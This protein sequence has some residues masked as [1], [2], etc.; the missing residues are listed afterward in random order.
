MCEHRFAVLFGR[1]GQRQVLAAAGRADTPAARGDRRPGQPGG[2]AGA[3]PG[4]RGPPPRTGI[5]WPRRRAS[6]RAGSWSTS[7]R[8]S[9]P[10]AATRQERARFIDLLLAARD[11]GSRLRVLIAVRADFYARCAEH[12]GLADALSGAGLLVGPMTADELREAVVRPAQAGRAAG[13]A[14]ADRADRG[15]GPRPSPADCRCS[16]TRCWRP[17]GGARAGCS[18]WPRTRRPAGCAARSRRAPRRCTGS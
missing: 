13:G 18:P 2:A 7:S 4:R 5:C 9:S 15:G 8:R 11:P 10:S 3:H 12:R 6:R 1:L 16:R 17:G 14:G